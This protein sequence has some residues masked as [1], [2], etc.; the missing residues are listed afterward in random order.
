MTLKELQKLR[1]YVDK[2]HYTVGLKQDAYEDIL[3]AI[4]E[5]EI[6]L[7]EESRK[8]RIND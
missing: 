6:E 2:I 7:K 3:S 8:D 4:V 1:E 5:K